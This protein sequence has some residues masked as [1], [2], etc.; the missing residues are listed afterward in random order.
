MATQ[1][2]NKASFLG[3]S[4]TDI[5]KGRN[6]DLETARNKVP[7]VNNWTSALFATM[8]SLYSNYVPDEAYALYKQQEQEIIAT[9]ESNAAMVRAKGEVELR[10]LRYQHDMA[11]GSDIIKVSGSGGNMS[12]SFL[13][14]LLQQRQYQMMDEKTVITNTINQAS[15]IMKEGYRNAANVALQ[16]QGMAQKQKYGVVGAL[17][18]GADKYFELAY[19]DKAEAAR[20][21]ANDEILDRYDENW[22]EYMKKQYNWTDTDFVL[23]DV[24]ETQKKVMEEH[25]ATKTDYGVLGGFEQNLGEDTNPFGS[26]SIFA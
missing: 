20:Q 7:F 2:T 1:N 14:A 8:K 16:A 3:M 19:K 23:H 22:K 24:Q 21:A 5:L 10:N 18:A 4:L 12:G 13:D 26:Q 9:A 17:L 11:M 25:G 15:A 6:Y